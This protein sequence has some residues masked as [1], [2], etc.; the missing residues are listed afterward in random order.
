MRTGSSWLC[1]ILNN[2]SQIVCEQELLHRTRYTGSAAQAYHY[3]NNHLFKTSEK[4]IRGF[5]M[6]YHQ[7][8]G[9][10]SSDCYIFSKLFTSIYHCKIIHIRRHDMLATYTSRQLA[11]QAG[12]WNIFTQNK[13]IHSINGKHAINDEEISK[14]IT[15]YNQPIKID[16]EHLKKWC[17]N[18]QFWYR[19]INELFPTNLE[20]FY[21]DLP[22]VQNVYDY[23][24]TDKVDEIKG[25]TIKLRKLP[26]EQTII[27]YKEAVATV[28]SVS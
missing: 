15:T 9:P 3:L 23:L 5:K 24:E 19:K 22:N 14:S 28:E 7:F 18:M 4:P 13:Y 10:N 27:N 16:L 2:H 1:T 20:V 11:Q 25:E 21:E 26:L 8:R 6:L 12:I 17:Q